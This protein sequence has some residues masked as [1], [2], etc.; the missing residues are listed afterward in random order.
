MR[1]KALYW[2]NIM[3]NKWST[4]L[5]TKKRLETNKVTFMDATNRNNIFSTKIQSANL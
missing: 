3:D 4:M 5:H 1:E 2:K